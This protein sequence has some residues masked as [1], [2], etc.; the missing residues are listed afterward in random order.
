MNNINRTL[1]IYAGFLLLSCFAVAQDNITVANRQID[2]IARSLPSLEG[3]DKMKAYRR[4][5]SLYSLSNRLDEQL[6][7]LDEE[8][9]YARRQKDLKAEGQARLD[10][11]EASYNHQNWAQYLERM[12]DD[13]DFW[14]DNRQ[15]DNYYFAFYLATEKYIGDSQ[16]Q[17]ALENAAREYS[18]AKVRNY[19]PGKGVASAAMG[20]AYQSLE[21]Y[22]E[23][24]KCFKESVALLKKERFTEYGST[25]MEIYDVL[26]QNLYNTG[27]PDGAVRVLNEWGRL[28]EANRKEVLAVQWLDW[29][30]TCG[31]IYTNMGRLSEAE[32]ML[33]RANRIAENMGGDAVLMVKGAFIPLYSAQKRYDKALSL[34]D[35]VLN[36]FHLVTDGYILMQQY[37]LA[38]ADSTGNTALAA[39]IWKELYQLND[40]IKTKEMAARLDEFHTIY[41][42]DRITIEKERNR[43]YF[44]FALGGCLLLAVALALYIYYNRK[45]L[46]RNRGL[47]LQIKEQDRLAGELE[48]MT[49]HCAGVEA[50]LTALLPGNSSDNEQC[51]A[52]LQ[53]G[54]V[55]QRE[56]VARLHDYL[57]S[58]RNFANVDIEKD[59]IVAVLATNRSS[60]SEALKAVTDMTLHDYIND[61]RLEEARQMLEHHFDLTA[62]AIAVDCGFNSYRTFS[63]LFQEKY[64]INP[65]GYR[66]AAETK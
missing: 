13:M 50:Q 7:C 6:A 38:I 9:R 33:N 20:L 57:R 59:D 27:D 16:A 58:E 32:D 60:L 1:L 65:G 3:Q 63:R 8:I 53:K 5:D 24:V 48:R 66:K 19:S 54:N 18:D 62:E 44:L 56:L 41:E 22:G 15:W 43:N 25:L 47:Y 29:Y 11:L 17:T 64:R 14:H 51:L 61:L 21:R 49:E 28:L 31:I 55:R 46:R 42:V 10:I 26:T 35:S 52:S 30:T 23:A 34:A 37:R 4:L 36:N 39:G 12:D 45:L 40:S 2:S